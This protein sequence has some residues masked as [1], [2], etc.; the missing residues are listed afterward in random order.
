MLR[1]PGDYFTKELTPF[2][3]RSEWESTSRDTAH[4]DAQVVVGSRAP[5]AVWPNL[6][7]RVKPSVRGRRD[8]RETHENMHGASTDLSQ[9]RPPL[10]PS[11]VWRVCS[12]GALRRCGIAGSKSGA[13]NFGWKWGSDLDA[14]SVS[15]S[16][17]GGDAIPS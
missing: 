17:F 3:K 2:L 7:G 6:F 4:S 1:I 12:Q 11:R 8:Q 13:G 5:E 14:D 10:I 9:G 16:N 15:G